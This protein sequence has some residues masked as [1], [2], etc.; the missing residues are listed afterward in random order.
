V[1]RPFW[2]TKSNTFFF[3]QHVGQSA[4]STNQ[5][6]IFSY[7]SRNT[8]A[9]LVPPFYLPQ[10]PLNHL[11]QLFVQRVFTQIVMRLHEILRLHLRRATVFVTS[12]VVATSTSNL[13][14]F[15]IFNTKPLRQLTRL[16][17]SLILLRQLYDLLSH[18][19]HITGDVQGLD[20]AAWF[21]LPTLS[22]ATSASMTRGM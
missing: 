12:S 8:S 5:N 10:R 18:T 4:G 1:H 21:G 19:S 17:Q 15:L 7:I 11:M 13:S 14:M 20:P 3:V 6:S 9:A 2:I 22:H 16:H